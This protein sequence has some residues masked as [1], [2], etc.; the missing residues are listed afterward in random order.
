MEITTHISTR[1]LNRL[2]FITE[3]IL[4]CRKDQSYT[5]SD[6]KNRDC[7]CNSFCLTN[8]GNRFPVR[9]STTHVEVYLRVDFDRNL[10]PNVV[11]S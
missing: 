5:L 11:R 6:T 3:G 4:G 8:S 9:N 1:A 2:I 7:A 10:H